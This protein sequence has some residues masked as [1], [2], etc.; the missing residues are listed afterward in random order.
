MSLPAYTAP[1]TTTIQQYLASLGLT[2]MAQRLANIENLW[3]W[4]K[5]D[6]SDHWR[7]PLYTSMM[8]SDPYMAIRLAQAHQLRFL[9]F[10][11]CIPE[12][13]GTRLD[14]RLW[15]E[16]TTLSAPAHREHKRLIRQIRRV[17]QR[18]L[19]LSLNKIGSYADRATRYNRTIKVIFAGSV[20][21]SDLAAIQSALPPEVSVT[22]Y[23]FRQ[24]EY[25]E[26]LR[27]WAQADIPLNIK[28]RA[29][30]E[31][32]IHGSHLVRYY[33]IPKETKAKFALEPKTD[34]ANLDPDA[35]LVAAIATEKGKRRIPRSPK[36]GRLARFVSMVVDFATQFE[37]ILPEEWIELPLPDPVSP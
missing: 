13:G 2:K 22:R 34:N 18:F 15:A 32:F 9:P 28:E 37:D 1:L 10:G 21:A 30:F 3:N 26:E 36:T 31:L 11:E 24:D 4:C 25:Q 29:D 6:S 33:G 27:L 12:S 5:I 16:K 8:R 7:I 20:S 17:I 23:H 14:F 19:P 35:L